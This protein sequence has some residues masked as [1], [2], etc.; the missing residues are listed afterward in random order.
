MEYQQEVDSSSQAWTNIMGKYF[1]VE[2]YFLL[3]KYF[4]MSGD[5]SSRRCRRKKFRLVAWHEMELTYL[6]AAPLWPVTGDQRCSDLLGKY[7]RC[8]HAP[9]APPRLRW[10][11]WQ[12]RETAQLGALEMVDQ[13]DDDQLLEVEK[14]EEEEESC[15]SLTL[16]MESWSLRSLRWCCRSAGP[17][18]PDLALTHDKTRL[19]SV[20]ASPQPLQCQLRCWWAHWGRCSHWPGCWS[21]DCLVHQ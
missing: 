11:C 20:S 9:L 18:S 16:M 21:L 2:K 4:Y 10:R 7:L 8:D 17:Q 13:E 12:C 15:W 5:N 19:R 6:E 1:L 3:L 14:V